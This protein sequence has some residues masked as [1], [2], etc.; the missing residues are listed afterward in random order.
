MA[1]KRYDVEWT[2]E[3]GQQLWIE[4]DPQYINTQA[5]DSSSLSGVKIETAEIVFYEVS[6]RLEVDEEDPEHD[7]AYLISTINE[8]NLEVRTRATVLSL[9]V[10]A[11]ETIS[12]D[13]DYSDHEFIM[14]LRKD[15]LNQLAEIL[16]DQHNIILEG[17]KFDYVSELSYNNEVYAMINEVT[18]G[19][20]GSVI[21]GSIATA[22]NLDKAKMPSTFK[23]QVK[24]KVFEITL[25]ELQVIRNIPGGLVNAQGKIDSSRQV[26]SEPLAVSNVP[27]DIPGIEKLIESQ[28]SEILSKK[29]IQDATSFLDDLGF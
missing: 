10:A 26:Q 11:Y 2:M 4:N 28:M 8:L 9:G 22:T 24:D 6:N 7:H 17:S 23:T 5:I 25:N 15:N 27:T 13:E 3:D 12:K 29:A 18:F 19:S 21:L 14:S 20:N 1:L 16:F